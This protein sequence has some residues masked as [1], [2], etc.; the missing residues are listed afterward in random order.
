MKNNLIFHRARYFDELYARYSKEAGKL[1][2]EDYSE[3][4]SRRLNKREEQILLNSKNIHLHAVL[5]AAKYTS[6]KTLNLLAF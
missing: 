1:E 4:L 3:L 2:W 5:A 6:I